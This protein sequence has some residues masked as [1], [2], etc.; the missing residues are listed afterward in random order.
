MF[1]EIDNKLNQKFSEYPEFGVL[2]GVKVFVTGTNIAGPFAGSLM[3][4]MGAKVLQAEAP[5]IACQTR[6]TYAWAQN[7]RNEYSITINSA[8][9][10]GKKIF[11]KCIEW[12]DIWIEAG[13]PGS[14][15]KRGLSDDVCWKHNKALTIVHVSGYGQFGPAKNK[16]SYDVSGQAMGGYMYMNGVSPTSS[17]LKV[18]PYLSDYVTAYNTCM[19]ALAGYINAK[20]SGE[21]DSCDVAQYDNMF[22]LLDEYP[23]RWYNKGYPQPGG[24]VPT[25]TGNKSDQAACF[26]FY[27]TKDGGAMFVA[28][29]GQGPVER[30]YPIIGMGKPGVDPEVPEKCTGFPLFDPRGKKAEALCEKFCAER[31]CDELEEIFNAAG[32]PCQRAYGPEDILN[33]PQFEAR[34][35][36]V[37]WEDQC[38]GKMKGMGPVNLFKKNPSQVV[39]AAPCFGEHNRDVLTEFGYTEE[40]IDKLYAKGELATWTAKDTAINKNYAAWGYFWDPENQ[41]KRLGIEYTPKK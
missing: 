31:T 40:E 5:N 25:R 3:A 4:E 29:V 37:E 35:N 7:H 16:P 33:D 1:K 15:A 13:R 30:G 24:P 18:N 14:Y 20:N 23:A 2:K 10:A 41:C 17:P 39:A 21:G 27:D 19:V 36:L 22:R 26:S 34:G 11:L 38:Y 28:I 9:P 12:A 6:G 32:I 8:S